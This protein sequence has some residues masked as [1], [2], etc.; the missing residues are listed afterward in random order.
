MA[1]GYQFIHLLNFRNLGKTGSHE[2]N[3]GI[4][5]AQ[6][7]ALGIP[8]VQRDFF[9]CEQEFKE[10][11]SELRAQGARIDGAVFG[12]IETHKRL[13]DRIC[14]DLEIDLLLPLWQRDSKKI[15]SDII[16]AGFE[17]II[18][19]ARD[20]LM[21]REWLDRRIDGEFIGELS[22]FNESIDSCGENGQ[23]HTLVTDGPIFDQKIST[24]RSERALRDGYWFLN[25]REFTYEKK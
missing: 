24:A 4:V 17:V 5:R 15:I 21:G 2:L 7:V 16:D 6:S 11:V 3:P 25:I 8:L 23:F 10:V 1:E 22:E 19:S 12:H 18:V 13:V 20:C 14:R 9:S